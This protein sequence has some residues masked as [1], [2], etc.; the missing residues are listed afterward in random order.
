MVKYDRRAPRLSSMTRLDPTTLGGIVGSNGDKPGAEA[1]CS[2]AGLDAAILPG[3]ASMNGYVRLPDEFRGRPLCGDDMDVRVHGGVTYGADDDGW[4][5]F[6]TAHAGDSWLDPDVPESD[7]DRVTRELAQRDPEYAELHERRS[8][9]DMHSEW[10]SIWTL[11]RLRAEVERFA[12]E[13]RCW[14]D[15][16]PDF[17]SEQSPDER[18]EAFRADMARRARRV[19]AL[20]AEGV[21]THEAWGR[22]LGFRGEDE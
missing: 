2:A 10:L 11:E 4:I 8:V 1:W 19:A 14:C 12:A 15:E 6:D 7:H 13:V 22:V 20:E 21:D 18:R 16:N 3:P 5:G 9:A 17:R